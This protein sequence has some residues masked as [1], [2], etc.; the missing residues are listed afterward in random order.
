MNKYKNKR[1]KSDFHYFL[2]TIDTD[3]D[4]K[5]YYYYRVTNDNFIQ[6]ASC[7]DDQDISLRSKTSIKYKSLKQNLLL[8]LENEL[9]GM[10]LYH[11]FP[12]FVS[13]NIITA[14]EFNGVIQKI[15][16]EKN[17]IKQKARNAITPLIQ[18]LDEVRLYPKPSGNNEHSWIAKCPSGGN[19]FLMAVTINDEWGCGY[20]KRKGKIKELKKWLSE[21]KSKKD[22]KMLTKMLKEIKTGNIKTKET[23]KWWINRY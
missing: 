10:Y 20:C 12:D 22:Q 8:A 11:D 4:A 23:L 5:F 17:A 18:Y 3:W 21:L 19:H 1:E 6:L 9:E 13:S 16:D 7:L 15:V 14:D 2:T